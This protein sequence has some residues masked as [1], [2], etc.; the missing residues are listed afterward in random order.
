MGQKVKEKTFQ[1]SG[2]KFITF[3][4]NIK[5]RKEEKITQENLSST[6]IQHNHKNP[7]LTKKQSIANPKIGD[8]QFQYYQVNLLTVFYEYILNYFNLI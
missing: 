8:P 7:N 4:L 6:I 1:K 2:F 5:L 3:G